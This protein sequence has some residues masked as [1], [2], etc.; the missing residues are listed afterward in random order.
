MIHKHCLSSCPLKFM[1]NIN[2]MEENICYRIQIYFRHV[3][4]VSL[5]CPRPD[6]TL[7]VESGFFSQSSFCN[8]EKEGLSHE[9]FQKFRFLK[10]HFPRN[11]AVSAR[12]LARI[13]FVYIYILKNRKANKKV[14]HL[15]IRADARP[16][17]PAILVVQS[18][19][20]FS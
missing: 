11:S 15:V 2:V 1:G 12:E 6:Q 16:L 14:D 5:T 8:E 20:C 3:Q 4:C 9:N 13:I 18:A 19:R 7:Y 10:V 17:T